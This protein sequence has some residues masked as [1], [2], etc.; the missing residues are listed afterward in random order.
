MGGGF[1]A[2]PPRAA[3]L[4]FC[5]FLATLSRSKLSRTTLERAYAPSASVPPERREFTEPGAAWL[6][7]WFA[8]ERSPAFASQRSA[9]EELGDISPGRSSL[10][11]RYASEGVAAWRAMPRVSERPQAES[12]NG[13][14]VTAK[15]ISP[16]HHI[17]RVSSVD[18]SGD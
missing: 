2:P 16:R 7:A 18:D 17:L 15:R 11:A 13:H 12:A 3:L 10:G 9:C 6:A 4:A 1:Q 5:A 14:Y 8:P